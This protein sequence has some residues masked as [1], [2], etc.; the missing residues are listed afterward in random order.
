MLGDH[1]CLVTPLISRGQPIGALYVAE[2][3]SA[4]RGQEPQ[5]KL[6]VTEQLLT[7]FAYFAATAVENARLYQD[8]WE[9]RQELEAVLAGIGDGVVVAA[10][11]LSLILMNPVARDILGLETEPPTGVPLRP[12]LSA[13]TP[14]SNAPRPSNGDHAAPASPVGLAGAA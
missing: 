6:N 3:P 2:N 13:R 5:G 8:A 7:S 10:P 9:K 4:A 11:D 12:Y 14:A 1:A